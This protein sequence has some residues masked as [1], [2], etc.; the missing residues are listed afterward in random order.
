MRKNKLRPELNIDK[1]M[2]S[3]EDTSKQDFPKRKYM[4]SF[5]DSIDNNVVFS[6]MAI[7]ATIFVGFLYLGSQ[8][9]PGVTIQ[10]SNH[11]K[12]KKVNIDRA[13]DNKDSGGLDR[14]V[15]ESTTSEIV[16]VREDRERVQSAGEDAIR[17][18]ESAKSAMSTGQTSEASLEIERQKTDIERVVES[19]SKG[20]ITTAHAINQ[21]KKI[22]ADFGEWTMDYTRRAGDQFKDWIVQYQREQEDYE[23]WKRETGRS[24]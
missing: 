2:F 5:I 18:M 10:D 21:I 22:L 23:Q 16:V 3:S 1:K 15:A 4:Q 13:L 11:F 24:S 17:K 14:Y 19:H 20:E 9:S 6:T 8:S 12:S 7:C